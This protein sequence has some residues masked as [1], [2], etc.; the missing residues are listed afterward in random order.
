M[1]LNP[2][3]SHPGTWHWHSYFEITLVLEGKGNYFVNG[4]EYTM[5]ENDI[6]I[7]NNV[8]P[9]GWKLLGRQNEAFGY[10]FFAGVCSREDQYALTRNICGPS[11]SVELI[12]RTEGGHEET[13]NTEIRTSIQ[14]FIRNGRSARE[15]YPLVIKAN[16]LRILTM[17]IRAYRDETSPV[18]CFGK[19]KNAMKRPWSRLLLT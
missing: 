7:F 10:D 3:N 6:I 16:V 12:L 15:G 8:E 5:K 1:E 17:L 9:H 4:Q 11:L 13:V 2:S 18:K 19:R 14:R